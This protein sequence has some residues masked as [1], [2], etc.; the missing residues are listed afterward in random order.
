[1]HHLTQ[2]TLTDFKRWYCRSAVC[3]LYSVSWGGVG[4]SPLNSTNRQW[5]LQRLIS[6]WYF[7]V[8][9][10]PGHKSFSRPAAC[11]IH[12][13]IHIYNT[14]YRLDPTI[15]SEGLSGCAMGWFVQNWYLS[16]ILKLCYP[17][18]PAPALPS[19]LSYSITP[20]LPPSPIPIQIFILAMSPLYIQMLCLLVFI[21]TVLSP[22]W[23]LNQKS[24]VPHQFQVESVTDLPSCFLVG[25]VTFSLQWSNQ[26]I[27]CCFFLLPHHPIH[28]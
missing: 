27:C 20:W 14:Y 8:N 3:W 16:I 23:T 1:M 2:A 25:P 5:R 21:Y 6:S 28:W 26:L 17:S 24:K 18:M 22:L 19:S 10:G 9:Q 12:P 15:P 11:T 4:G 13:M 7:A